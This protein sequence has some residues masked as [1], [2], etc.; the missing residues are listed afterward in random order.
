VQV[1]PGVALTLLTGYAIL[2]AIPTSGGTQTAQFIPLGFETVITPTAPLD[3]GI[4][5][6]LDGWVTNWSGGTDYSD[7]RTV[8]LWLRYRL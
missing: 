1:S 4:R 3:I 2:I 5:V 7:Q 8:M 6:I